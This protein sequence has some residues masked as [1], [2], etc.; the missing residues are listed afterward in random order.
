MTILIVDDDP[1][2]LRLIDQYV[3]YSG[4][5]TILVQSGF[6]ALD[7]IDEAELD[8][9]IID[10]VMPCM[11]GLDLIR[12]IKKKKKAQGIPIIMV[13]TLGH[14]TNMMLEPE[15][16][17]DHYMSKPFRAKDFQQILNKLIHENLSC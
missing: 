11:N 4:Y 13:S 1:D 15:A 7:V 2:S 3:K 5:E 12:R 8:A 17:A 9:I 10:A 6:D 14:E 16:Q